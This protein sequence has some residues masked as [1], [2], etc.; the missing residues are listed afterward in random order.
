MHYVAGTEDY[1]ILYKHVQDFKL[2]GSTNI[3]WD[4]SI[5]DQRSTSRNLFTLRS[6][7][8]TWSSKKQEVTA[9]STTKTK[10]VSATS[11]ACQA[12]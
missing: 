11:V 10:Y 6:S 7:T 8:V 3:D 4:G 9:L 2:H 5:D 1:G 12:I